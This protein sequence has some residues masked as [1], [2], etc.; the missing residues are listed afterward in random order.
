MGCH[1]RFSRSRRQNDT[2]TPSGLFPGIKRLN[3]VRMWLSC[4]MQFQCKSRPARDSIANVPFPYPRQHFMVVIGFTAPA[5][6]YKLKWCRN[7]FDV[8]GTVENQR[9]TLEEDGCIHL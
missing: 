4:I 2:S 1:E 8:L 9:A 7:V 6:L 3:L 5:T